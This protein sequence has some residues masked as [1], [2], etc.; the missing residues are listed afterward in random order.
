[1][2][3]I[4]GIS[5]RKQA[6]KNTLANYI[7]G[8]ILLS[9]EM[10]KGFFINDIGQLVI[11]TIDLNNNAGYGIFDVTRKDEQFIHYAE[12]ELWPYI[13]VYHFADPLK[14]MAVNLFNLNSEEVYGND[15]QK[16]K[17]T[18]IS[19]ENAPDNKENK[20]GY[21]TNREFLEH[22]GTKI[23]RKMHHN[24]WSEYTLKKILKEQTGIAIIPDVR[25][26]NEVNDIK[27]NG[28]IVIRLTRDKYNSNAEAECALDK[29]KFDWNQ[30]DHVIDNQECD[31]DD[32]INKFSE[33]KYIWSNT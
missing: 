11:E 6:G 28:G 5:G 32:L 2:T 4:I 17:Q 19:W 8:D 29:D 26:P 31:M 10:I 14:E 12:K 9:N 30:F 7:N 21:M 22:F 23:V 1:M 18:H 25:F 16:N 24:A 3:K 13:K 15:E 27:N 33:L 20:T